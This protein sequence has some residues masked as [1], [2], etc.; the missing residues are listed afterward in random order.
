M[1]QALGQLLSDFLS[2]LLF[3]ATYLLSGNI[4]VAAAIA[5]AVGLVQLRV[6]RFPGRPIEPMQ[7][8]SLGLVV[9]LSGATILTQSPRFVMLKPSIVHFAIA[10]VMLRRGWMLR[11]LPEIARQNLPER[12]AVAAGYAWAGLMAALGLANLAIAGYGD[13]T[14][15][16]WFISVV[17]VGAKI[18]AFLPQYAV[19]RAI[20]RRNLER[21]RV[22]EAS[23]VA[24]HPSSTLP[25]IIGGLILFGTPGVAGAVGFQQVTVPDPED[26]PFQLAIWY[27]SEAPA[28][29]HRLGPFRQ[30]VATDGAVSGSPLPLVV[31]SHG[32]GGTAAIHY[33]T[34]LALAE[35]GFVAAAIEHTGDNWRDRRYSFTERNFR[36]RP[37]H[38]KL[39]IDYLLT[40]W[41]GRDHIAAPRIGAL[42]HSAGAAAVLVA[43]GG[44]PDFTLAAAF[45]KEH[46]EDWG[47]ARARAVQAG[48]GA[49]A[50]PPAV[51]NWV[52]DRRIKAAAIAAPALGHAFTRAGLAGVTVPVQLWQAEDDRIAVARWSTD[53]IKANLRSL[54]ATH[55]VPLAG[56]FAFLAPCSPDLATAAPE[57]CS[58]LLG[59][60]RTAFHRDFNAAIVA[61]FHKQLEAE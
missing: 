59:F 36:D 29:V 28:A 13:L 18:V 42:G 48:T 17:A 3:L 26:Q 9:V 24:L 2:A 16:A 23:G 6:L 57:I 40:V 39:A 1:K 41:S 35:A 54:P 14:I 38:V 32:T 46:A 43:I 10:A 34:A 55:I 52:H 45:C 58:D 20:V 61:C 51:P 11:Y 44:E 47:C 50:E 37:R 19:F 12:V 22:T 60:D 5:I 7:W 56:H 21:T 8:M 15:W 4:T 53:M 30:S 27:P 49:P 25:I 33:D 31:I